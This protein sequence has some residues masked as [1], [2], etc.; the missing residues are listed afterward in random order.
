M[1]A[2]RKSMARGE[3]VGCRAGLGWMCEHMRNRSRK[4]GSFG[5]WGRDSS[6]E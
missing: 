3:G 1:R 5:V 6:R 2:G 4:R